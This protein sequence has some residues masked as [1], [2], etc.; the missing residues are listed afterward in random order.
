VVFREGKEEKYNQ[1][2]I[3]GA[4]AEAPCN[5]RESP[6]P[7]SRRSHLAQSRKKERDVRNLRK[8]MEV[9][10]GR[11]RSLLPEKRSRG[12]APSV[13]GQRGSTN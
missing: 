10:I 13:K 8:R 12:R 2:K 11:G 6:T 1:R 7:L 5:D 4:H 3:R 9:V